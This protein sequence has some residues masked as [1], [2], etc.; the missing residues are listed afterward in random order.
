MD[1]LLTSGRIRDM[2]LWD[3]VY[4]YCDSHC[5]DPRDRAFGLL[6]LADSSSE[7][8]YPD[9]TKPPAEVFLTLLEHE[10]FR[11]KASDDEVNIHMSQALVI[12][13]S[14]RLDS[15]DTSIQQILQLRRLIDRKE[16]FDSNLELEDP[17]RDIG[18]LR[19]VSVAVHSYCRVSQ[20][21]AGELVAPLIKKES[22]RTIP[23]HDFQ[24]VQEATKDEAISIRSCDGQVLALADSRIEPG[25]TLVFFD[26][27]EGSGPGLAVAGMHIAGVIVRP[28]KGTLCIIIGQVIVDKGVRPCAAY[29]QSEACR[30]NDDSSCLCSKEG[31]CECGAEE[32]HESVALSWEVHMSS[33]DILLFLA[34]DMEARDRPLDEDVAPMADLYVRPDQTARR[35]KNSVTSELLSSYA[36]CQRA[37]AERQTSE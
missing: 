17:D 20:D 27:R 9:Y 28:V 11:P 26:K 14:F 8:F 23:G 19:R 1:T 5:S 22:E 2:S 32:L 31:K 29:P 13:G 4:T 21:D 7:T 30:C 3:Q 16:S 33:E 12:L 18:S 25:D 10:A 34:Q 36:I 24:S 35:L 15:Y 6:A 37:P